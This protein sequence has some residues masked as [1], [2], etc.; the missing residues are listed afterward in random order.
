MTCAACAQRIE[1]TLNKDSNIYSAVINLATESGRITFN[2]AE[3]SE[4]D[5]YNKIKK[6]GY[7]PVKEKVDQ[8]AIARKE[9]QLYKIRLIAALLLSI[10]LLLSMIE[11]LPFTKGMSLGILM[12]PWFQIVPATIV[13][14]IIGAPFYVSAYRAVRGGIANM[15]VLVVLG[16]SVA[17]G[18]SVVNT[19]RYQFGHLHHPVLYFETSAVLITFVLLGKYLE[20]RAKQQTT[21]AITSLLQLQPSEAVIIVEGIEKTIPIQSI[22]VGDL[23]KVV[24]GQ[25]IPVDGKIIKGTTS[26]DES[27]LTGESLP[28]DKQSNDSVIAGSVNQNGSIVV[29]VTRVGQETTL[30]QIIKIIENAQ[31]DK[32]PIQRV[33]DKISSIFVPAV[34]VISV[35]TFFAWLLI[36]GDFYQAING[37]VSVLVIACPCALGLATPTA[38]MVG[39][40]ASAKHGILFKGG[41]Y[42]ENLEKVNT[43]VFDKT[44]TLTTGQ[45]EVVAVTCEDQNDLPLIISAEVNSEH[46]LSKAMLRYGKQKQLA[47]VD[48]TQFEALPGSGISARLGTQEI[49]IGN[50]SLML[51]AGV[52]L[53][54][55]SDFLDHEARGSTLVFAAI[56]R[57][58]VAIFAIQD[59]IKSES[60][61][62]VRQLI[63]L[64]KKVVMLSGDNQATAEAIAQE[65]GIT[66]VIAEVLPDEKANQIKQL[67]ASQSVA[68]VGDGINDAPALVTS[69]VG[70]AMGTGS[71]VAIESADVTLV[72]GETTKVVDAVQI[73]KQTMRTIREN[74]FWAL[75]YN[76]I[77]IPIAA[78]GL[79]APWIAGAA[80][81]FSSISVV[82]NSLRLKFIVEKNI[83]KQD[84]N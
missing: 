59:I 47:L 75:I 30:S 9:F 7:I 2:S 37:A 32:V 56:N 31:G 43:I 65:I 45:P 21:A 66:D 50:R 13:Q 16:T 4:A 80:M 51:K 49:L 78:S 12:N 33:A 3:L 11:H 58:N 55:S 44:G 74:L 22:K 19:F 6:I 73:S 54:L 14:F 67:Q 38:I 52:D 1:R 46:P 40:G 77:G 8:A 79:L 69:D 76:L 39:S 26:V 70:I 20:K 35:I 27:L 60:R 28:V 34:V 61:L 84:N 23:V 42:L 53:Q 68:M 48:I 29:K 10:P 36:S 83:S 57:K 5:I 64:G 17:Y 18:L 15:D 63:K 81:A 82:L 25:K 72:S 24:P 71:D 41:Q 62:A